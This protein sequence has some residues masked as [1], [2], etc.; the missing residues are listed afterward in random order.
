[1]SAIPASPVLC[2]MKALKAFQHLSPSAIHKQSLALQI[3]QIVGCPIAKWETVTA[4]LF[5]VRRKSWE[6]QRLGNAP[7]QACG[8]EHCSWPGTAESSLHLTLV[9]PLLMRSCRNLAAIWYSQGD[10]R[11]CWGS[12]NKPPSW[13]ALK[14]MVIPKWKPFQGHTWGQNQPGCEWTSEW[15]DAEPA[16]SALAVFKISLKII[17]EISILCACKP[18]LL[19][20]A[21]VVLPTWICSR[22]ESEQAQITRRKQ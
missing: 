4:K 3:S 20:M 9:F 22:N 13:D 2:H 8:T 19:N 21:T 18:S 12:R 6:A 17:S 1:M 16:I 11:S 10:G 14:P 15:W 5:L 7:Q